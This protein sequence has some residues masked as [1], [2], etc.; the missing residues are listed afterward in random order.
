MQTTKSFI[1]ILIFSPYITFPSA[2]LT[3]SQYTL[4]KHS[5]SS[6]LE[7]N[8][9]FFELIALKLLFEKKWHTD[10][11]P[12]V[13]C[14]LFRNWEALLSGPSSTAQ[15]E[16]HFLC[17]KKKSCWNITKKDWFISQEKVTAVSWVVLAKSSTWININCLLPPFLPPSPTDYLV[18]ESE[19][20]ENPCFLEG[21]SVSEII[22]CHWRPIKLQNFV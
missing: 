15:F 2:M 22:S 7:F 20:Y 11:F 3:L 9:N 5:V 10:F 14:L 19:A 13:H 4:Q 18:L 1:L 17:K 21:F 12:V 16:K 8:L 6:N